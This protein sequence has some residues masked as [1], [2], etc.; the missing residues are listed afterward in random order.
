MPSIAKVCQA[1]KA[2]ADTFRSRCVAVSTRCLLLL[3]REAQVGKDMQQ[4]Q[5]PLVSLSGMPAAGHRR[6]ADGPDA[7][8]ATGIHAGSLRL[9]YD[10][11][12]EGK[13]VGVNSA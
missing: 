1:A 5:Q 4:L 12:T 11:L 9:S 6:P 10:W 7:G 13:K 2:F 8:R 3:R